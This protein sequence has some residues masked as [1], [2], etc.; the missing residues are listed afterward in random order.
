MLYVI[1]NV[2]DILSLLLI[3]GIV[4]V[5]WM[6]YKKKIKFLNGVFLGTFLF[7]VSFACSVYVTGTLY[8]YS[9]IDYA[10]T[11]AVDG[12]MAAYRQVDGLT[13]AQISQ[14]KQITNVLKDMY[15]VLMPTV[16]V[17]SNL[18]WAYLSLML[19]KGIFA[20][21]RKDV[22]GFGKFC[23]FKMPQSAALFAIGAYVLSMMFDDSRIS[24]GFMNFSS[25]IFI[26]TSFCGL[27]MIDFWLR[28]KVRLSIVRFVIYIVGFF[29][30]SMLMGMG[31][32]I[33]LFIGI[34]DASFDFRNGPKKIKK[35]GE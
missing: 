17:I 7:L 14:M 4:P 32:S 18:M 22:S 23:D 2:L 13:D 21:F 10:V 30:L 35:D 8:G 15:F 12:F 28:K 16:V 24:F 27:S 33:I 26:L 31:A 20:L 1:A 29:V 5:A 6:V 3:I 19:A 11:S 25:I 34:A 9:P